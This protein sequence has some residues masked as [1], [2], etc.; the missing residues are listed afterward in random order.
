MILAPLLALLYFQFPDESA[1]SLR[2][3]TASDTL[4]EDG[5]YLA[6]IGNCFSCHTKDDGPSFGGGV[7]FHVAGRSGRLPYGVIYSTNISPDAKTGIGA[8]TV[9]EFARAMRHGISADGDHLYPVFPY[10]SFIKVFDQDIA[11]IFAYLMSLEPVEYKP[12]EN[13]LPF[14]LNIRLNLVFWKWLFAENQVYQPD[15]DRTEEWNRGAYLIQGLGHCG[16]CHSP[17]TFFLAEQSSLA[18]SGGTHFDEVEKGKIRLWSAVN[19]TSANSG[20]GFWSKTETAKY[21]KTGHNAKAG[22]FGPMNKVIVNSTQYLT[23][24]DADAM[25][26]FLNSL[27]AITRNADQTISEEEQALGLSVYQEHCEECHLQSGRGAF[28]KA[29]PVA[30]SAVVQAPEPW[31]LVNVILYGARVPTAAPVPFGAWEDMPAYMEKLNDPE[32]AAL[33]NYLRTAWGN[34][35]SSITVRD[36][37]E[38]R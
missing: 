18:F 9:G 6:S 3:V 5:R 24:S 25:A 7:A 26:E 37:A 22:S 1:S 28:L 36:V 29:P 32:V 34:K 11:A 19:L 13:E 17:R 2:D 35:G 31:S 33:S 30:A 8:W 23:E 4:V 15:S 10:T 12:P 16:A 21:L 14:P 38:Q 27:P 20:L